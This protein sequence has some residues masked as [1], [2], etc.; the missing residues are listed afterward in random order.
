MREEDVVRE[1]ILDLTAF[2][3]VDPLRTK[4][5]MELLKLCD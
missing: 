3:G 5:F 1:F 4:L 2:L